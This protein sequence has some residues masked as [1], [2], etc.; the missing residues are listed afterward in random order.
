MDSNGGRRR[1]NELR[2]QLSPGAAA[3]RR[4]T[5]R[6]RGGN[7][8][9]AHMEHRMMNRYKEVLE[10]T[11][12]AEW[13]AMQPLVQ[14]VMEARRD[15]FGGMGRMFGRGPRGGDNAQPADQQG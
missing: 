3:R 5:G 1:R 8:E 14:K 13:K 7:V 2:G 12:G 6:R 15:S 4:G 9:P 10:G 11:D